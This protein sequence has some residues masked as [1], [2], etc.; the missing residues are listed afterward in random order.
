MERDPETV[1]QGWADHCTI[2]SNY[3]RTSHWTAAGGD[4]DLNPVGEN[5]T[6]LITT[7]E[8][9]SITVE[10]LYA[11]WED[12]H[13]L[14]RYQPFDSATINDADH[15]TQLI[16]ADTV[17]VGCA[18]AACSYPVVGWNARFLVCN[19]V[20]SG[21]VAGQTPYLQGP[22]ASACPEGHAPGEG[23]LCVSLSTPTAPV[24]GKIAA[25]ALTLLLAG[26][27]GWLFSRRRDSPPEI[28]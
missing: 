4:P 5:I 15:F 24:L 26:S 18:A 11:L 1:A 17:A 16:W 27:V 23:A 8:A 3:N 10:Q 19:Y 14:W 21:N 22:P 6:A 20:T 12:E 9:G 7:S 2:G 13:D 25:T 28:G